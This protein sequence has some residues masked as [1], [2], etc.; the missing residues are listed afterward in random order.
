[1]ESPPPP[2]PSAPLPA[3]PVRAPAGATEVALAL[4]PR[5][6]PRAAAARLARLCQSGKGGVLER[7]LDMV[8]GTLGE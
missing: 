3:S 1:M 7:L 5:D 8:R 2:A 4:R 6:G